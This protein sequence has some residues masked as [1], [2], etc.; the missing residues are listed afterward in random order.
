MPCTHKGGSSGKDAMLSL[1]CHSIDC[2]HQSELPVLS[3]LDLSDN[4]RFQFT[5]QCTM[6]RYLAQK[7]PFFCLAERERE[8]ERESSRI[9]ISVSI[10]DLA[11]QILTT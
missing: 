10:Q 3:T 2:C 9:V 1:N 11:M 6:Q 8:R 5:H 7:S 4:V